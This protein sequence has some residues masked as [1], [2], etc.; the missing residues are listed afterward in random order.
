MDQ[1]AK[2]MENRE[3]SERGIRQLKRLENL[4][5]AVFALVIVLIVYDLETPSR[6]TFSGGTL[7][8]FLAA[9]GVAFSLS[10]IGLVLVVIYW[11]QNNALFGCLKRTDNRHTAASIVQIFLLL[12]YLYAI[13]LGISFKGDSSLLAMQ[14]ITAASVGIAAGFG[15]WYAGKNHRLLTDDTTDQQVRHMLLKTLAEPVTALITL[16]F[17]LLGSKIWSAAWLTYPLVVW[18]FGRWKAH[19]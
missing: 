6:V 18:F 17:S 3:V 7:P 10:L 1:A 2:T 4:V 19:D 14:S 9:N 11:L 12:F 13:G 8:E 5:D 15:W 16:P